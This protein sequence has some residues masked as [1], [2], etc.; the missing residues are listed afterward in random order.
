MQPPNI[1]RNDD[2]FAQRPPVYPH[3]NV[4]TTRHRDTQRLQPASSR[5]KY[6]P[7]T[8]NLRISPER[9]KYAQIP[10]LDKQQY[11]IVPPTRP[12]DK[13]KP[14]PQDSYLEYMPKILY[15]LGFVCLI[16]A[17]GVGTSVI[18]ASSQVF[19]PSSMSK[20]QIEEYRQRECGA[21]SDNIDKYR[22]CKKFKNCIP[23]PSHGQCTDEGHLKCDIGYFKKGTD[24][25]EDEA[26]IYQ[27]Y[28][29]LESF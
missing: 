6:V 20:A 19:C 13:R 17:F 29:V 22:E 4:S 11:E 7:Y 21:Y 24:C 9:K 3:H 16:I 2:L 10:P 5:D 27:A 14:L 23:C 15:I 12:E 18:N 26:L 1:S 25:V 8:P 28:E